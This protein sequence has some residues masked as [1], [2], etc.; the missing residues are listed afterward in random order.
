M[1]SVPACVS[2]GPT[3]VS[4][5]RFDYGTEI[6]DSWKQQTLINL[7]RL[8]Y[9]DMPVFVEVGQIVGGYTLE[10]GVTASGTFG[11]GVTDLW[12]LGGSGKLTDRPTIT[13]VPITGN[14]FLRSLMTPVSPESV[15]FSIQANWPADI[16]FALSVDSINGLRNQRLTS[17]GYPGD[18]D[19]FRVARFLREAQRSGAFDMRIRQGREGERSTVLFIRSETMSAEMQAEAEA[20]RQL[21]GLER[22]RADYRLTYG[23]LAASPDEMAVRTRSMLQVMLEIAA[24]IDVPPEHVSEGR[25]TAG[26]GS[27]ENAAGAQRLLRISSSSDRPRSSFVS[28]QHHDHW[29]Y[30][31]DT[32][33]KSKGVFTF[34]MLLFTLADTSEPQALPL[35]TIPAG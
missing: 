28:V 3:T 25:A 35:I 23:S 15:F 30:I 9:Y 2:V 22:D 1:L 20:V 26:L 7:V 21:L 19:F 27:L 8:R 12:S 33:L 32:D 24:T 13:Y 11:N 5:D 29:F 34:L 17:G 18:A 14:D 6:G 10:T 16:V 31:D 4:R